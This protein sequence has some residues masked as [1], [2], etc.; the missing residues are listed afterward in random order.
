MIVARNE[1]KVIGR[2]IASLQAQTARIHEVVVVDDGSR[3]ATADIARALGCIVISLPYHD[4]SYVGRPELAAR[5]NV[6]LKR[7]REGGIPDFVLQMG[8]DHSLPPDYVSRLITRMQGRVAIA[9]GRLKG[10]PYDPRT[11]IGSGRLINAYF[12]SKASGLL[13]PVN[14][15]WESWLLLKARS[16]SYDIRCYGDIETEGRP[17]RMPDEKAYY[18][19]ICMYTLGYPWYYSFLRS[20]LRAIRSRRAGLNMLVGYLRHTGLSRMD[21]ADYVADLQEQRFRERVLNL[22]SNP[23]SLAQFMNT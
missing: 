22:L 5:V 3:D 1:E 8:A 16:M 17:V 9:S 4:A 13:Y 20:M 10:A 15:G 19:G 7:I 6:G 21:I 23:S 18:W 2:T 14:W 12:W 11:P